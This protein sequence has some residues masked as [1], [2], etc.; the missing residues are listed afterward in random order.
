MDYFRSDDA[1]SSDIRVVRI[2]S[3]LYDLRNAYAYVGNT[4]YLW[5]FY[6]SFFVFLG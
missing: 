4:Y 2:P 6:L 3:G 1:D 5:T